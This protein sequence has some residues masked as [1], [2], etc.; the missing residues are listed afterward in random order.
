MFEKQSSS[1]A[2]KTEQMPI[3]GSSHERFFGKKGALAKKIELNR[4][5]YFTKLY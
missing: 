5:N 1:K 2:Q 3:F 4:K